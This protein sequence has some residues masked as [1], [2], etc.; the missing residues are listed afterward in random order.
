VGID[1]TNC[2]V[3]QT[4]GYTDRSVTD[5]DCGKHNLCMSKE[6]GIRPVKPKEEKGKNPLAVE[7]GARILA[8]RKEKGWTVKQMAEASGWCAQRDYA[9]KGVLNASA[10]SNYEQGTR[11]PRW[12]EAQIIAGLFPGYHPAYFMGVITKREAKILAEISQPDQERS[13]TIPFEANSPPRSRRAC[14]D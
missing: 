3:L 6:R 2:V 14:R 5:G 13:A 9:R 10:I 8:C 7:V 4:D 12:N 1:N 11:L